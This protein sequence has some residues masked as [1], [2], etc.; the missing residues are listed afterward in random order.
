MNRKPLDGDHLNDIKKKGLVPYNGGHGTHKLNYKKIKIDQNF[1]M[2][3]RK[4]I[5]NNMR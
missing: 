4:V 3:L 1:V 2:H 5:I